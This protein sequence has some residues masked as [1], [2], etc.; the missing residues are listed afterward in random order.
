MTLDA[1][2]DLTVLPSPQHLCQ[3]IGIRLIRFHP[4][5]LDRGSASMSDIVNPFETPSPFDLWRAELWNRRQPYCVLRC[6]VGHVELNLQAH[7][8][9]PARA[10]VRSTVCGRQIVSPQCR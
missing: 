7:I 4:P 1:D 9:Q 2:A 3:R 6:K 10:T 8:V 5:A